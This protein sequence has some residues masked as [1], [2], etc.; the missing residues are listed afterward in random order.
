MYVHCKGFAR[1]LFQGSF[2]LLLAGS[3]RL[4]CCPFDQ[5]AARQTIVKRRPRYS[6]LTGHRQRQAPVRK[7]PLGGRATRDRDRTLRRPPRGKP[8]LDC[9]A[10]ETHR[11]AYINRRPA[12]RQSHRIPLVSAIHRPRHEPAVFRRIRPV[13]IAPVE[14]QTRT[15]AR[16]YRP[17]QEHPRGLAPFGAHGNAAPA[18]SRE[19]LVPCVVAPR[20]HTRPHDV[21]RMLSHR[22]D[23]RS[24]IEINAG[25]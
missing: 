1:S 25:Q 2:R 7:P 17:R 4:S 16:G 8:P 5:P 13:I 18:I 14:L 9:L 10:M 24:R 3:R 6:I 20:K 19:L 21:G 11:L 15:P 12:V 23:E 22:P